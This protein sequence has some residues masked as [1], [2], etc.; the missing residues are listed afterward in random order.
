MHKPLPEGYNSSPVSSRLVVDPHRHL[1][2]SIPVDFVYWA[3]T[4]CGLTKLANSYEEVVSA[5]CFGCHEPTGFHRFLSKFELL[6]KIPWDRRLIDLSIMAVCRQLSLEHVDYCWMDFSIDKYMRYISRGSEV[7][8]HEMIQYIHGLFQKYYPDKVGLILSLKY[9][10]P[11]ELQRRY[12]AVI[13]DED[14]ANCLIGI[15]L[16]GDEALFD[17][18]FYS[19]ILPRWREKGKIVRAHVAESQS[20]QNASDSIERLQVSNIGH[21]LKMIDHPHI[22]QKAL[23]RDV[24]ID[25]GVT[26]NY[27]ANVWTREDWH[28]VIDMLEYGLKVT[29]GT[30]DPVQ[31]ATNLKLERAV[32]E[33]WFGIDGQD[34]DR[35]EWTAVENSKPYWRDLTF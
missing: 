4:E 27:L 7:D 23:E 10:S 35:M 28:P 12:A 33:L 6:N 17:V 22:M 20:A 1:G 34:I 13:E 29:Y 32:L 9:E 26:S 3:L 8:E 14:T 25:L 15:D 5:M 11:R 31:C 19:Q 30:D 16:V 2:G 18:D 24:T 21:G